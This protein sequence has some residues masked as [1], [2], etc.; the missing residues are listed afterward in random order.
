[1]SCTAFLNEVQLVN[2]KML[3]Q[4]KSL[5]LSH[6]NVKFWEGFFYF[7]MLTFSVNTIVLSEQLN[8]FSPQEMG[9]YSYGH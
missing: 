3:T 7:S 1:M 2:S 4:V 9:A 6:L 5:C 8:H